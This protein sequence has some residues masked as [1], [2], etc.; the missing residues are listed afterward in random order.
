LDGQAQIDTSLLTRNIYAAEDSMVAVSKRKDWN[1]YAEYMHPV[2]IDMSG[3]REGF[4]QILEAQSEIL[5]SVQM[6][7]VGKIFQLSKTGSQYQCIV[8]AFVQMK[9]NGEVASGSSYD[10]AI[11]ENG[12]KWTFFRIPPT[13]TSDQI[14]ELLPG[15]N[16]GFKFPRSQTEVGK[17]LDEFM[18]RYAIEY[19]E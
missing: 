12:N 16:P 2:V 8:E 11:S 19:L 6:Y 5:D 18:A 17:T 1:T 13:A 3:G 9:I 14:K 10:I 7:K 4:I 15:L